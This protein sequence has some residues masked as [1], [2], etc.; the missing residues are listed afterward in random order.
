MTYEDAIKNLPRPGSG[1]GFHSGIM[2][3]CN[4]GVIQGH[5]RQ[6][7]FD[8]LRAIGD[9]GTR[10]VPDKEIWDTIEEAERTADGRPKSYQFKSGG[11]ALNWD[12]QPY[13]V[14]TIDTDRNKDSLPEPGDPTEDFQTFIRALFN[15]D[16]FVSINQC[17]EDGT[18]GQCGPG[19]KVSDLLALNKPIQDRFAA[20]HGLGIVCNPTDGQGR[21]KEHVTDYKYTL[22]E[23]DEQSFPVERQYQRL[24]ELNL[25]IAT[26]THSGGK[27]V[28]AVVRIDASDEH[29][30][31]ERVKVLYDFLKAN[32]Y[33]IDA[34]NKNATRITRL[35][36]CMRIG[37]HQY[38]LGTNVGPRSWNE[39]QELLED[40]D[41]PP[42]VNAEDLLN[43]DS[44]QLA[45]ELIDG[46]LRQGH[47]MMISGPSKAGKSWSLIQLA[48]AVANGGTW[49]GK[50]CRQG[51]VLYV[52][53][54]IDE[55]SFKHR[56]KAVKEAISTQP[57]RNLTVW[58]LRGKNMD[59]HTFADKLIRKIHRTKNN[60]D[61]VILDPVYK[62]Q[63]GD[64]NS[65]ADMNLF[66]RQLDYIAV[67][68]GAAVVFV[69]HFSKGTQGQK[70]AIDR[71]SGS[72]VLSRDPDAILA[73]S[74]VDGEP[75]TYRIESNLREFPPMAP[76]D[77]KFVWPTHVMSLDTVSKPVKGDGTSNRKRKISP[78]RVVNAIK[79][80][81]FGKP[82]DRQRIAKFMDV[83]E[84]SRQLRVVLKQMVGDGALTVIET[85]NEKGGQGPNLYSVTDLGAT[86]N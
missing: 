11:K 60:F 43:D 84:D 32:G 78:E 4:L 9:R 83:A 37:R 14:K 56:L 46:I 75:N 53:M 50:Q 65:A 7:I 68:Q 26:M 81:G 47:K 45:P 31:K 21:R 51:K 55:G 49:L 48:L 38:L 27:S 72:G 67:N 33:P 71:A 28:H 12:M 3:V 76:F 15:D 61:M 63:D 62:I 36:G 22:V 69:H 64:E 19:H 73:M 13:V 44:I 79:V 30:Y 85:K 35:P 16:D 40:D 57:A 6:R 41:L 82:I 59:S 29:E 86:L 58:T 18:W 52:N 25:P 66:C 24:L 23:C 54:E 17:K 8:D 34:Q 74:E 39:W 1:R 77:I 20:R 2:T 80:A 70:A 42:F 10:T 5:C